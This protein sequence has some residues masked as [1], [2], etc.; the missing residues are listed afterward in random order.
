MAS[1]AHKKILAKTILDR[2]YP[3]DDV[4]Y[5]ETNFKVNISLENTKDERA[6]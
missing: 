2:Q 6:E 3:R 1:S 5:N 4:M